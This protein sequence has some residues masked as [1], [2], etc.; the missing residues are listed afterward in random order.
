MGPWIYVALLGA[1]LVVLGL[2]RPRT[3]NDSTEL[4]RNMEE[5][6]EHYMRE[7]ETDNEKLISMIERMK[8]EGQMTDEA[9]RKRI[10]QLEQRWS[11]SEERHAALEAR[12]AEQQAVR[13]WNG[14]DPAPRMEEAAMAAAQHSM[15]AEAS[16][17]PPEAEPVPDAEAQAESGTPEPPSIRSRYPELF[18]L[19][20]E[21]VPAGQIAERLSMPVGEVQLIIQLGIQEGGRV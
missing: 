15:P 2:L 13:L 17:L 20:D 1:V 6:L 21:R 5:T 18:A 14:Q 7:L 3:G 12:V 11:R 19:A 16:I 10:D 8:K 9:L 4:R